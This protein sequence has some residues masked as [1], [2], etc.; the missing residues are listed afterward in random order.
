MFKFI[1]PFFVCLVLFCSCA[2][3][4][5]DVEVDEKH[6]ASN[7]A[8]KPFNKELFEIAKRE[9][10]LVLLNIGANWCHWCHVMDD[11][12]Y[13]DSEVQKFLN[14]N[15]IL[16]HEDQDSRADLFSKYR[17]YGWPATIVFN[18]DAEEL[19]ALK[20]YQEKTKF[21]SILDEM[22]KN[23]IVK[24]SEI[25]TTKEEVT[26]T[27]QS[28]N[29][30]LIS[31][32][33]QLIDHE[34][35][36]LNTTKKSL[37]KATIDLALTFS[38]Q[39][40]SLKNWLTTSIKNS[41][42][43]LDPVWGGIYQY[44]TNADWNHQ[45]FEKILRVQADYISMYVQYGF[46]FSDTAAISKA[47]KIYNYCNRFLSDSYPLFDNSQ[48]ADYIAGVESS[49]YYS[50]PEEER[51]KLGTPAVNHQQFLK[52]NA[53]MSIALVK[54]WSITDD[55]NYLLRAE[56]IIEILMRDFY[57]ASRLYSRS[58]DDNGIYS[59]E[60]NVAMLEA[61]N[62]AYQ[63]SGSQ[64]YSQKSEELCDAILE[65]FLTETGELFSSCGDVIVEPAIL[66]NSNYTAAF[67][68]HQ[69]GNCLNSDTL[70]NSAKSITEK[71]YESTFQQ[72]E[73]LIPYI[74]LSRKYFDEEPFHAVWIS[75]K[76]G[77]ELELKLLQ[78]IIINLE[79]N[80]VFERINMNNMTEEQTL[81]YGSSEANTLFMC[82][83]TFCSSP[84]KSVVE[85]D[86][87]FSN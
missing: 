49:S 35:G 18:S 54:L 27:T 71:I 25:T 38:K 37:N 26:D 80:F 55:L 63:I 13:A 24:T 82:T 67:A 62:L 51:L 56:K 46:Q 41:Y 52:E 84:I 22:I 75:D 48:D 74:L 59:L 32:F 87:F 33:N 34:K 83:S 76:F 43:L 3:T 40:D 9:D 72:S 20:G 11:S 66:P 17:N 28:D 30:T 29:S 50:L 60:D 78:K 42:Q 19:L 8:W 1:I 64:I 81:L 21:I 73:Y 36:S 7:I 53:M 58:K 31:T 10:K 6:H 39:N 15:F 47:E 77:S 44:S 85:L 79:N 45:H 65:N 70:K 12:T 5:N 14:E 4:K 69:T 61:L 16:S 86:R 68:I 23:P 2:E 57:Q